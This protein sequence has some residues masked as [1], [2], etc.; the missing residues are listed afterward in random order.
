MT[1][2][3]DGPLG[4][5]HG[6]PL[7]RRRPRST[8]RGVRDAQSQDLPITAPGLRDPL[9][10]TVE[11]LDALDQLVIA[12]D[13]L[14]EDA[15]A[16]TAV[17][18]WLYNGGRLWIMLDRVQ[19]A[20]GVAAL[21]DA[22]RVHVIDRIGLTEVRLQRPLTP[23]GSKSWP[24]SPVRGAVDLVRVTGLDITADVQVDGWPAA[25]WQRAGRG[26]VLFTTLGGERGF[27]PRTPDDSGQSSAKCRSN[28]A[29][30]AANLAGVPELRDR[31]R[32]RRKRIDNL[33]FRADR[34]PRSS[35]GRP[36]PDPGGFCG[37]LADR[38]LDWRAP[39]GRSGW[40]G[41]GR[42]WPWWQRRP[43]A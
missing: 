27:G 11:T 7:R 16:L 9:P 31:R 23:R 8:R 40:A 19:P 3:S 22:M 25:F 10:P 14:A 18:R 42:R 39:A 37:G 38:G 2:C 6:G 43:W 28:G 12:N 5:G 32:C 41:L 33:R 15:A 17:R 24:G 29:A 4:A 35:A 30:A 34:I 1:V 26:H 21:G 20:T 13:R 36:S